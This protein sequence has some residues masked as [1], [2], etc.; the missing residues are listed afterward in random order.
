MR[1]S[2]KS[3]MTASN[4]GSRVNNVGVGPRMKMA[5]RSSRWTARQQ[6]LARRRRNLTWP[7]VAGGA[8][9]TFALAVAF[10]VS[11]QTRATD[12]GPPPAGDA[13]APASSAGEAAAAPSAPASATTTTAAAAVP[14]FR[15]HA[16]PLPAP[17]PEQA[18]AY[19]ATRQEAETYRRGANDYKDAIT[20][21]VTLHYEEKKKAILGG[22]DR[23]IGIEKEEL[24]KARETAIKRLEDFIA[25]YRGPDAQPKAPADAMYRLPALYEERARSDE[26][27]STDFAI[28]LKPAIALYRRVIHEFPKYN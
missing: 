27:P 28:T 21:I 3:G 16:P 24:K 2:K 4:R 18:A 9:L 25:R 7:R 12:A 15:P 17:T 26:D 22:L 6:R 5:I 8:V 11:A 23:E 20:T 14:T 19:E 1:S 10:S 13:G